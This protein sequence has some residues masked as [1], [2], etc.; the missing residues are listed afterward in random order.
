M[1]RPVSWPEIYERL[2]SAPDG[3]L[4]GIPR[5]GAIVAGLTGRAVDDIDQAD[6]IVD[7]VVDTG[8][9]ADAFSGAW[10]KPVWGLFDR[11]ADGLG[12]ADLAF[13]WEVTTPT[14]RQARIE[15]LGDELIRSLGYDPDSADLRETP[16]R[17]ARWWCEFLH[18]DAARA[19]TSFDVETN[20]QIVIVRGVPLWS[21][22]EHHLLPFYVEVTLAYIP[23]GRVV[24]L[25]KL[26]RV[27]QRRAR[28]LQIQERM[29][30]EIGD[31]VCS[32]SGSSDVGVVGHGRH[33][34]MEARGVSVATTTTSVTVLGSF[35]TDANLRAD[36][37]LLSGPDSR[38]QQ[39][40]ATG[41]S[42][43]THRPRPQLL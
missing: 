26:V 16:A 10:N 4:Y 38:A 18:E 27:A 30:R 25:S 31:E 8:S 40:A 37:L 7:D 5:G 24:G 11:H 12:D 15:R 36:L 32:L 34:C 9:T 14:S 19:D 17:W 28:R 13:P 29:I 35:R 43:T 39:A 1:S 20:E 3:R 23:K 42:S 6:W 2:Q 21:V 22:C 41:A 33:M